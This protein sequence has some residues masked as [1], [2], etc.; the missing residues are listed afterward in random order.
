MLH[1]R[2]R[3]RL[4]VAYQPQCAVH[5]LEICLGQPILSR[6]QQA[7]PSEHELAPDRPVER[8]GLVRIG[9]V[10]EVL[11]LFHNACRETQ[12]QGGSRPGG[13]R[14]TSDA[15]PCPSRTSVVR[16][17]P[18]REKETPE[19]RY[20]RPG[21]RRLYPLRSQVVLHRLASHEEAWFA[22]IIARK[23][24]AVNRIG[25]VPVPLSGLGAAC[26]KNPGVALQG[27]GFS[28]FR[29]PGR[30]PGLAYGRPFGAVRQPRR[31]IAPGRRV[32][33]DGVHWQRR[34]LVSATVSTW[35]QARTNRTSEPVP[36]RY[37]SLELVR[38]AEH[39]AA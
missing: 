24:A 15:D 28:P 38:P 7:I 29:V 32:R 9:S 22:A 31:D 3:G 4:R 10:A 21:D 26:P 8:G 5:V 12:R 17:G 36:T 35:G 19:R 11:G 18:S 34:G 6:L 27:S 33:R 13:A 16:R 23:A 20:L 25:R 14:S 2:D 37:C 39:R 30:C 1:H